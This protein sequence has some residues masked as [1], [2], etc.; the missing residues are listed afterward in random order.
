MKR[1]KKRKKY[2]EFIVEKVKAKRVTNAGGI[3]YLIKWRSME[4]S[5]EKDHEKLM[6]ITWEPLANLECNEMIKQFEVENKNCRLIEE[7]T[8]TLN[9]SP[10]RSNN[11]KKNKSK[12]RCSSALPSADTNKSSIE[13]ICGATLNVEVTKA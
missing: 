12:A 6:G 5:F 2:E 9:T 4:E 10:K 8:S 3:E 1:T 13:T 11:A 7:Q